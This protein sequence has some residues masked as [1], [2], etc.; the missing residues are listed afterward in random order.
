MGHLQEKTKVLKNYFMFQDCI[1]SQDLAS[2]FSL[3]TG[4]ALIIPYVT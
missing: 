3:T 1:D 4:G 2:V